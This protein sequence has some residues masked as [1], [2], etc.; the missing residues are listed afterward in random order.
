MKT[1]IIAGVTAAVVLMGLIERGPI[2]LILAVVLF[3][4][5]LAYLEFDRLFFGAPLRARHFRMVALIFLT[6]FSLSQ[7][8]VMGWISF[9]FSFV[10]ICASHV[11]SSNKSGDFQ[12]DTR[13]L[14]LEFLGYVYVVSLFGFMIPIIESTNGR[15]FLFLLFLI[16]FLGDTAAY[17]VGSHFGRRTLAIK[18]SPKKT[19]EGAIGAM[20][21]S[22]LAAGLFLYFIL[23]EP[24]SGMVIRVMAFA[25]V[26]S[27][28]AQAGDLFE[29]LFK[30]SQSQ[31]D[32]GN[33]L[34][35]H[36]GL[37]DRID[38]LALVSPIYYVYLKFVLEQP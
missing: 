7:N 11:Y 35:G 14:S 31:K 34:P 1:R 2:P 33:F 37:L 9:W 13:N 32:S 24:S 4:A 26:A 5:F 27:V 18:L 30:R 20:A 29:S 17:F 12:R 15:A 38:G 10:I 25:P 8:D 22:L 36:G 6:I 21:A 3:C 23:K 19:L 28:L 16:V